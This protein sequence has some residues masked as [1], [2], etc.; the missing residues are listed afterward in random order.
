MIWESISTT[1][2]AYA[3][4]RQRLRQLKQKVRE[5]MGSKSIEKVREYAQLSA[6]IKLWEA[7][8]GLAIL[9]PTMKPLGK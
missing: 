3:N 7:E 9:I 4:L 2:Q 1:R 6:Y 5:V 8:K